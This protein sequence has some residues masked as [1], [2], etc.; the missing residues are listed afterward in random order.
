MYDHISVGVSDLDRSV[1]VYEAALAGLGLVC[2]WRSARAAG[3]GPAGFRGE[4]PFALVVPKEGSAAPSAAA[5]IAF[6]AP[7]RAAVCA[8]HAGAVAAGA[9]DDG[10]PGVREHYDPGYF[11]AFVIDPDGNRIE[12]VVHEGPYGAGAQS[13]G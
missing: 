13:G 8:F 9:T 2:L 11:A 10:P 7:D 12:A 3:F 4:A 6:R 5:H 1:R